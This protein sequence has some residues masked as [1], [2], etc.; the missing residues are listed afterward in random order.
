MGYDNNNGGCCGGWG[1]PF[2]GFMNGFGG[3]G[4]DALLLFLF[5]GL[6][7]GGM[8]GGMAAGAWAA[9]AG[10]AVQV[11]SAQPRL[12]LRRLPR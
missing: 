1:F 5:F 6:M 7:G 2:G 4:F 12:L 3:L 8:W 10:V 9:W 11:C